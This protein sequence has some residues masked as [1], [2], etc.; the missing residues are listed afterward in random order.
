MSNDERN[1]EMPD[2]ESSYSDAPDKE[3]VEDLVESADEPESDDYSYGAEASSG[4]GG[5][6]AG[7]WV[8]IVLVIAA[9]V[10]LGY[11]QINRAAL[12]RAAEEAQERQQIRENQLRAAVRGLPEAQE[13]LERGDIDSMIAS[14]RQMD[15][16]LQII[17]SAA[18][19]AG[20]TEDAQRINDM[21][22]MVNDAIRDLEPAYHELQRQR[23]E[24]QEAAKER[25]SAIS[26]QF[27]GAEA[28]PDP[29]EMEMPAEDEAVEAPEE[30]APVDEEPPAVEDDDPAA[31][32]EDPADAE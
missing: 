28:V 2:E 24:L 21:R 6:S 31:D 30:E 13:A 1:D 5:S 23:M 9:L 19:Q 32:E 16:M 3:V 12:E 4:G 18:N 10:G 22:K 25:L 27:G 26:E 29:A 7:I 11:Y 8:I 14:L 20:D 17:G 15:E